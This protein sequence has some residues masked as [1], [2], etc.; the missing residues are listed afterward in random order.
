MDIPLSGLLEKIT[1]LSPTGMLAF[2]RDGVIVSVNESAA[3]ILGGDPQQIVG[4]R[5]NEPLWEAQDSEGQVLQS[6][7][8]PFEAVKSGSGPVQGRLYSIKNKKGQKKH[9]LLN[10]RAVEH[11]GQGFIGVLM[12]LEDVTKVKEFER[13]L[14]EAVKAKNEELQSYIYITSHDLRSPLV[15]LKGFTSELERSCRELTDQL[16]TLCSGKEQTKELVEKVLKEDIP[17]DIYFIRRSVDKMESLLEGLLKVSRVGTSE[18]FM[19]RLDMNRLLDT[20]VQAM[21]YELDQAGAKVDIDKLPDCMGDAN[22]VNQ[23]FS[24]L[25]SN[26]LN[27]R[28]PESDCKIKIS[29]TR[30]GGESIYCVSDNG[31][32][33]RNEHLKSVF[34]IF[35]RLDPET[36][37]QGEGLGLTIVSR[38]AGR[39]GGRVWAESEFNRGSR[40]YLA[41][42]AT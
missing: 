14:T 28:H 38:I 6:G 7:T 42:P 20:V 15:N 2:N 11:D 8:Y 17:E 5:Y 29:G 34:E 3:K 10:A 41:L 9:V 19:S 27:Y 18:L 4:L 16:Q 13:S 30:R 35:N 32:G 26:A 39:H 40:F 25:I 21:R 31:V 22:H 36:S 33:I 1:S 24:N 23:A 12:H 37:P